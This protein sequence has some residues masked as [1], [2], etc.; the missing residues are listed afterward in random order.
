MATENSSDHLSTHFTQMLD[1]HTAR[2]DIHHLGK[3][4]KL[5]EIDQ[6]GRGTNAKD[7]NGKL[8]WKKYQN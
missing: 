3:V 6:I 8:I 5:N 7:K 1:Q 4:F 2:Q